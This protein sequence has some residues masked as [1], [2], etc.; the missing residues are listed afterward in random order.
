MNTTEPQR[1]PIPPDFPVEWGSEEE[2][3]FWEIDRVHFLGPIPLLVQ[4]FAK[5]LNNGFSLAAEDFDMTIRWK[6]KFIHNFDYTAVIPAV[7]LAE[8]EA[9][10]QRSLKKFGKGVHAIKQNWEQ[11]HLPEVQ[12]SLRFWES[13]DLRTAGMPA[14]L[15]HVGATLIRFERLWHIHFLTVFPLYFAISQFDELYSDLF[16][17]ENAL[18]AYRLLQGFDNKTLET[19]RAL[20]ALSQKA[21]SNPAMKDLFETEA[22]AQIVNTLKHNPEALEFSKALG[23]FLAN[24]GQR[25]NGWNLN[26]VSWIEDPTTVVKT[27]KEYVLEPPADPAIEMK[28]LSDKREQSIQEAKSALQGY[29]QPVQ[30]EFETML[31]AAQYANVLSEDHGFWIDFRSNYKVRCVII[32]FGRRFS[33]AGLI[34]SPQ[35]VFHLSLEQLQQ[36]VQQWPPRSEQKVG[37]AEKTAFAACLNLTPPPVLGTAPPGPPPDDP[38][39]RTLSK[40]FGLPVSDEPPSPDT[41]SLLG[42]AG[43][44]GTVRGPAKV[45]LSMQ[46][47][48]KLQE[49]DILV[50][51][52]TAPPWTPLFATAAAVVTDAGGVLCHCAVVA[53]EYGIPA[54]VGTIHA[55]TVIQDGQMLEVNGN[56]GQVKI[57]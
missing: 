39:A 45:V 22:S 21:L 34:D 33:E 14:L 27:L 4:D 37:R 2:Q 50:T 6:K 40:F 20:W 29:P 44:S 53:R 16:G 24:Y 36:T 38:I 52:T 7:P 30:D 13:F 12:E 28:A 5:L 55:T 56:T 23:V 43:S 31:F 32:E 19:D 46:D 8:M 11:I 41:K 47:A 57:V 18:H 54:V 42:H 48:D 49:G 9:Q 17:Q 35:D 25:A 3:L 10:T 15:D 26:E 51:A 1:L